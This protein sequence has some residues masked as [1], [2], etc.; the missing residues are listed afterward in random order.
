[1]RPRT[2][3]A[4]LKLLEREL[5]RRPMSA[6]DAAEFLGINVRN[7]RPYINLLRP[8]LRVCRWINRGRGPWVA[9]WQMGDKE[10]GDVPKP[11]KFTRTTRRLKNITFGKLFK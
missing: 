1:M 3:Q 2:E 11:K 10:E 8:H 9:V 7:A 5:Q 6:Y 4:N